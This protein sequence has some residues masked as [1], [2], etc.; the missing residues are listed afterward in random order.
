MED[1]FRH[2]W[3]L[4][5]PIMG[6]TY[7]LLGM[8]HG[9][10]AQNRKLDLLRTYAEQGKEPPP[11]LIR[12][13][14]QTTDFTPDG[15]GGGNSSSRRDNVTGAWWTFFVFFALAAGFGAGTNGFGADARTAFTVVTVVMGVLAVGALIMA[16]VATFAGRK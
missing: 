10:N 7:G 6:M 1:L 4:I 13:L 5:F 15:S 8:L 9:M 3:W 2:F 11:E 14:N 12:A 16:L